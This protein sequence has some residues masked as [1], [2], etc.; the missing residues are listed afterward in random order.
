LNLKHLKS[1]VYGVDK[2]TQNKLK[3]EV[4][5]FLNSDDDEVKV[6]LNEILQDDHEDCDNHNHVFRSHIDKMIKT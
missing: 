6:I 3:A 2:F 1:K 4:E 5:Q